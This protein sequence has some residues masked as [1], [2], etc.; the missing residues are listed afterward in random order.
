MTVLFEAVGASL[1]LATLILN[2]S[3]TVA[4]LA[5]VAM[6]LTLI[7]PTSPLTGVPLKTR[8]VVLKLN[9]LGNALPS[10]NVA[11]YVSESPTSTSANVFAGTVKL[12]ALFSVAA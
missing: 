6:T 8:V 1:V 10:A 7:E 5:S 9:Q 2:V 11:E 12:N 4:L 3:N